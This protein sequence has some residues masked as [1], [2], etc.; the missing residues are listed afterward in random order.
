MSSRGI[1]CREP[2]GI[3]EFCKKKD[4]LRPYGPNGEN[5]CFA[6]AMKDKETAKKRFAQHA[7]GK[8]FDA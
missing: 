3:C 4:E 6:C 7:L 2:D 5:I 8:D 1:I